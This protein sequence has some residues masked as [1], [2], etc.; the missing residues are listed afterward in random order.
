MFA[1]LWRLE[2]FGGIVVAVAVDEQIVIEGADA[3]EDATL[4]TGVDANVVE[5]G[6]KVLQIFQ[7]DLEHIL[8]FAGEIVKQFLKVALI[9]VE[10]IARHAALELQVAHV[11]F[12]DVLAH[13]LCKDSTFFCIFKKKT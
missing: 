1:Y 8:L 10:R 3:A 9:G 5:S 6:C 2:E 12:K 11:A 4:G 13:I 7:G